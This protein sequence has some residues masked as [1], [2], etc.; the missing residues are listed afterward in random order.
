MSSLGIATAD[1]RLFTYVYEPGYSE[2]GALELE[3]HV[4]ARLG[5]DQGRYTGWDFREELEYGITERLKTAL[6]LNFTHVDSS[7]VHNRI[8]E[9]GTTFKGISS[10]WTYRVL[11]PVEKPV[12]LSLYGEVT[13]SDNEVEL[14]EKLILGQ[15]WGSWGAALNIAFEQ[16]WEKEGD[17]TEEEGILDITGGIARYLNRHWS[18]GLEAR[19]KRIFPDYDSEENSAWFVGPNV[20]YKGIRWGGTLTVLPQ[21][22]GSGDGARDDLQL[23]E[24]ER[25]EVRVIASREF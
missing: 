11:D 20:H 9:D 12:G 18:V 10:E 23:E 7:D 1:N 13:V 17:E 3:Q 19:N 15:Y 5:K 22:Y 16:E 4:T 2:Q 8:D 21:V 25:V 14:E 6:Y 24:Y